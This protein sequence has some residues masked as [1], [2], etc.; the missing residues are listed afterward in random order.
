MRRM[1]VQGGQTMRIAADPGFDA[2]GIG[3]FQF[4]LLMLG[5]RALV[6]T[7]PSGRTQKTSTMPGAGHT[8]A[9][10]LRGSADPG[11]DAMGI[12][13]FQFPLLMLGSRALVNTMPSGRTQ[14]TSDMKGVVQGT[15]AD[16]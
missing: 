7:M 13:L 15:G 8:A 5:S 1:H 11:F 4:P 10:P 2:M 3:L 16:L 12:G 14:K 9:T 6:N